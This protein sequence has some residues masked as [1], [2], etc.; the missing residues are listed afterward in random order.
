M[1]SPVA[2]KPKTVPTGLTLKRVLVGFAIIYFLIQIRTGC[3]GPRTQETSD[4][5][6]TDQQSES[7]EVSSYVDDLGNKH[8]VENG[9]TGTATAN[10]FHPTY[11]GLEYAG[12][13][14]YGPLGLHGTSNKNRHWY[15]LSK[16][17][18]MD[19]I[20]VASNMKVTVRTI[21]PAVV[22]IK[23]KDK[24]Y[25]VRMHPTQPTTAYAWDFEAGKFEEE[26][27]SFDLTKIPGIMTQIRISRDPSLP[28]DAIECEFGFIFNAK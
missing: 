5:S 4:T 2:A 8:T 13:S 11:V 20:N 14:N 17:T 15:V 10:Q 16:T 9:V 21:G 18:P 27:K 22:E 25:K 26:L 6:V 24:K 1:K 12:V 19:W 28:E 7:A 23:T 3:S